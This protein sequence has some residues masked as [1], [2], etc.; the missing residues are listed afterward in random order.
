MSFN[1]RT[2]ITAD[3]VA[4]LETHRAAILTRAA[5]HYPQATLD[6][7]GI[8]PTPERIARQEIQI[9]DAGI[10]TL[11][12]EAAGEIIGFAIA[13][14]GQSELRSLYVRPNTIGRV[15]SGLLAELERRAF[16]ICHRLACDASLN[17]VPF[18]ASH[19]YIEEA[20]I[21][22]TLSSGAR[23]PCIRMSKRRN[24]S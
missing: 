5:S 3:A 12:A 4:I 22:H 16:E 8:G 18:Y 2:A 21:E 13:V 17:A 19:G 7:W 10:I 14:P 6:A 24:Q 15:G 1:V 9:A 20:R 23:I 11:V